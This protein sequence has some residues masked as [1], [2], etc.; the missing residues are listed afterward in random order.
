MRLNKKITFFAL[1]ISLFSGVAIAQHDEP[2]LNF[3]FNHLAKLNT[4]DSHVLNL[5]SLGFE[6][7]NSD[8]LVRYSKYDMTLTYPWVSQ[9]INVDLGLTVRHLSEFKNNSYQS[10]LPLLHASALYSFSRN[11]LSAG[12]E[13]NHAGSTKTHLFDYKAKVSYEWRNGFGMQGG[14][15]HQQFNLDKAAAT[16]S[17]YELRGPYLDVYLNF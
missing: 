2:L 11:G 10:T 7:S 16:L 6:H 3:K 12:I 5:N 9:N 1:L 4:S 13:S 17:D 15:Q 14:W 8:S